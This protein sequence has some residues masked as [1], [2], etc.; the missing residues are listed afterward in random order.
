V[1]VGAQGMTMS[2]SR[3][4]LDE[5]IHIGI[6]GIMRSCRYGQHGWRRAYKNCLVL[7]IST[8][9]IFFFV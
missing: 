3:Q 5:P 8:R 1:V 7:P 2:G 6:S 4:L 9:C